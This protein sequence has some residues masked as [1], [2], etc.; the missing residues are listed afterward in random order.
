M[1]LG[2]VTGTVH[3]TV[4]S[5]RL[6]GQRLMVVRPVGLDGRPSGKPLVCVDRAGAGVSE[7]VLVNREGGAARMLFHDE[8]I[9]IQAVIVGIVDRVDLVERA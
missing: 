4:R 7:L 5:A 6:D 8:L 2:R 9:P 3:A 1:I